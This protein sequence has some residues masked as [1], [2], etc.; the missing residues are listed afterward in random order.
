MTNLSAIW[1][2]EATIQGQFIEPSGQ[3][4]YL[5]L[6]SLDSLPNP[7]VGYDLQQEKYVSVK[8]QLHTYSMLFNLTQKL[9]HRTV[10]RNVLPS[11]WAF[12][13]PIKLASKS[14]YHV[15]IIH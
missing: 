14:N 10:K 3:K 4:T 11:T 5:A 12:H 8:E 2:L 1:N 15:S 6:K 13:G 7:R 9:S